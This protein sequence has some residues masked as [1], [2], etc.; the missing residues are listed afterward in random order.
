MAARFWVTGGTGNWN[1]T[2]NWSATS[3]G[4][5][6][7]SVPGSADTAALN[8]SSGSGTIT[9]DISPTI[10]TL[11]CTGFT[12]TLA[13]GTNTISLNST[14]TIFTGVTTMTVTGTPLIICTNSSATARTITPTAVTEANSIS[15][16]ITA[17]TGTLTLTNGGYRDV[18][19]TDGVNPTGYAGAATIG[20]TIY[21]NLKASTGMT[22]AA[23]TV[24][25]TFAAT[26]GTKTINT[27]GVTFDRPFIFNGVGGTFQLAS[28]LTSGATRTAT[29][30]NGTLDLA[31]YTLTTGLFSSTNTNTR[32]LAF[33]TGKIV[34]TGTN[35]TIYTTATATGLTVT[36]SKTV[37]FTGSGLAGEQRTIN[38]GSTG[39]GGTAANA[40]NIYI[41]AGV[42]TISLGTIAR[43]FGTVDFTGFSGSTVT[44]TTPIIYGNLVLSTG[45]TVTAG[46]GAWTFGATTS[47]TITS[48]GR[49]LDVPVILNGVGGT[50]D[51]QDALTI[52]STRTLSLTNGTLTTN[53]YAVTTGLFAS[54]NTNARTLNLG[55]S[56]FTV[57]STG[58]PWDITTS[59]NMTLNSGTSTVT[60][61]GNTAQLTFSGGGLTYYNVTFGATYYNTTLSGINT[62]NN[63]TL[64]SPASV[65][66]RSL[67]FSANQT[68][69][70]TLTVAG[71]AANSRPELV[72]A[73]TGTTLTAA[74]V[75]L[76]NA[77]FCAIIAAGASSPWSGTRLGNGGNNTNITFATPKT[78]YWNQPA[79][80]NWADTAW[81][82]SSGGAVNINN[83]PLGQDTA[84][85]DNTG[86]SASSNITINYDFLLPSL[87]AGSLTNLLTLQW[88]LFAG[89]AIFYGNITLSSSMTLALV[90]GATGFSPLSNGSITSAGVAFPM[91]FTFSSSGNVMTL[92]DAFTSTANTVTLESGT[93]NLNGK[94]LS[95]V[96]FD[97]TTTDLAVRS[98]AFNSGQINVTGFNSTVWAWENLT[99][100]SYTGTPTVNFTYS[101]STGTRTI[102]NGTTAGGTETNAVDFN[103]V[104]GSDSFGINNGSVV[105]DFTVQPAFTGQTGF[106]V[107]GFIYGNLLL[108]PSQTIS[109]STGTTTFA[110]T[111]GTKTI[112]T[113]GIT[114]DRSITFNGIGGTWSLQ[115][116]LTT[117][118]TKLMSHYAGTI[119]TNGYAVIV[120]KFG[121][122][123]TVATGNRTLNLGA[124]SFTCLGGSVT[125]DQAWQ[126][127][128][129]SFSYT[130]NAGT[131]TIYLSE[132]FTGTSTQ[133]FGGGG[134]TY[135]NVVYTTTQPGGFYF[136]NTFNSISSTAQPLTLTFEAGTTQTVNNFNVSGT[137]GNLVTMMSSIPG[138]QWSLAKA[139]GGKV[140]VSYDSITDSAVTPAGYWFAPTSQGNVNGGN[141]T[142]W[143]F[144]TTG[145][146]GGFLPFF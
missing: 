40:P 48:N 50:W 36:G 98:I 1:S 110:A 4:A 145:G 80:G 97:G 107:N 66:H 63:L 38:S 141:N 122:A 70:G 140:L 81:A 133:N 88:S 37:E 61:S 2:T 68:I 143:N 118:S 11:T 29:L 101:G 8:A 17:G 26:S 51:L 76:L 5:S 79:G 15:F 89:S 93:I 124:S 69:N 92:N 95:C 64:A 56:T 16:R 30:T 142:G 77:D 117:G 24:A 62:F 115:D 109:S 9:L 47:Q 139:T 112:T 13:F 71:S 19:L 41:K 114:I 14:G 31:S 100:F 102:I 129:G 55:A 116:A 18:D 126:I 46:T 120:G 99:N 58:T 49:T 32:T 94:T 113:N 59:T 135:Y 104:A 33:G 87:S 22:T 75:S 106:F 131:S 57:T 132:P 25:L 103:V 20:I 105:R 10:Q 45:M 54:S 78:V 111:S 137:S 34:V 44:N 86:V 6:G 82:T 28:A 67:V 27:A 127:E 123:G 130:V 53:G 35:A 21:G 42:D 23:G 12:G 65:G 121:S 43:V 136:S 128:D 72:G 96:V 74:S 85:L 119:T 134:K 73:F 144:G 60:T 52:G 108:S 39:A 90:N 146:A 125:S 83:F 3:G 84:I 7:A 138:T 91:S